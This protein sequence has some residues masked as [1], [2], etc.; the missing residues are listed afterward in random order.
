MIA[1]RDENRAALEVVRR[2]ASYDRAQLDRQRF[3]PAE[4]A[5]R[6]GQLVDAQ[7]RGLRDGRIDGSNRAAEVGGVHG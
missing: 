5:E 7:A 4:A 6:F 2:N 3:D 1:G